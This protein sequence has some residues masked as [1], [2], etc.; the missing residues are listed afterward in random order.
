MERVTVSERRF[1]AQCRFLSLGS[2]RQSALGYPLDSTL[3]SLQP[4]TLDGI[5]RDAASLDGRSNVAWKGEADLGSAD[6][7]KYSAH[8]CR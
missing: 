5:N 4:T 8:R 7:F 6:K 3:D 2:M 1:G